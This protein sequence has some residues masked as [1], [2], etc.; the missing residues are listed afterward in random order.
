MRNGICGG[1]FGADRGDARVGSLASFG[2]CVVT[3]IEV[4]ALLRRVSVW[5]HYSRMVAEDHTLSL[6]C[7]RSFLLGSLP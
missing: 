4:F 1:M 2:E 5:S 7:K 6:F 3:R